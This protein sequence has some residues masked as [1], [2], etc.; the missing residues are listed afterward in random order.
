MQNINVRANESCAIGAAQIAIKVVGNA[1]RKIGGG[2][3][4]IL[5]MVNPDV[6]KEIACISMSSYSYLLPRREKIVD[7]GADGYPPLVLVHGLGGNR[8]VWLP[9]RSFM[10]LSGH[11]RI[12]AFGYEKGTIEQ[13]ATSLMMF[14]REILDTTGEK[15]VDIVAHSLG[16]IMSR[17]AI[18]R[19]GIDSE[20]RTLVTLATPHQGTYAATYANTP[21]TIPLRPESEM[22]RD[23]NSDDLSRYKIRFITVSSDRDVYVVPCEMMTHPDAENIFIEKISHSQYLISTKVF[24]AVASALPPLKP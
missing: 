23:L 6:W 4:H 12:Y 17:Y 24:R 7:H 20:V 16:G 1:T 2:I 8:G 13:H 14:I 10:R 18:Q 19:L 21:L 3:G 11:K 15:Q 22:I 5:G 9:L